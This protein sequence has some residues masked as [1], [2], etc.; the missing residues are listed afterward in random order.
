M[1]M[2]G[3]MKEFLNVFFLV[4]IMAAFIL[5]WISYAKKGVP[6]YINKYLHVSIA[7]AFAFLMSVNIVATKYYDSLSPNTIMSVFGNNVP[8]L[9]FLAAL[10]YT[11]IIESTTSDALEKIVKDEMGQDITQEKVLYD[12]YDDYLIYKVLADTFLFI[13]FFFVIAFIFVDIFPKE[14]SE[15]Q[16]YIKHWGMYIGYVV[17]VVLHFVFQGLRHDILKNFLTDGFQVLKNIPVLV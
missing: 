14:T 9:I 15:Y 2:E 1:Y 6:G 16:F 8:N 12:T 17:F 4:G 5:N 11:G 7:V 3:S 13:M 10:L